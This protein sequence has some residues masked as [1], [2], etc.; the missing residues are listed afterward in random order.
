MGYN[1]S[2]K[3]KS[4]KVTGWHS[5]QYYD[6]EYLKYS[7]DY[8]NVHKQFVR[9]L[10]KYASGGAS[11]TKCAFTVRRIK[12]HLRTKD[13]SGKRLLASSC[14]SSGLHVRDRRGDPTGRIA[15]RFRIWNSY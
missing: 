9:V 13:S 1:Y 5:M 8:G 15:A 4:L 11:T 2:P 7:Y 10:D 12:F 3:A 6:P 14:H